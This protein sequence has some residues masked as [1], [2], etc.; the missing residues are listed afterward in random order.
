M[1]R[2]SILW[3]VAVFSFCFPLS[4]VAAEKWEWKWNERDQKATVGKM[5]VFSGQVLKNGGKPDEPLE[6]VMT[7]FSEENGAQIFQAKT[8]AEKGKFQ[9]DF[10]F[11]DGSA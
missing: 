6:I 5:A 10:Q 8:M 2:F 9:F 4:A 7:A 3:L 11:Y 1:K